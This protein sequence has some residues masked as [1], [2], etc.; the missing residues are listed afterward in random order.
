MLWR[1]GVPG[2]PRLGQGPF[3]SPAEGANQQWTVYAGAGDGMGVRGMRTDGVAE[4]GCA[5]S[6]TWA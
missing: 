2:E 4:V 1:A 5:V 3:Y 6:E